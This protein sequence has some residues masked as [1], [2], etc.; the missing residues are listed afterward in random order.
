MYEREGGR[1][2]ER[3]EGGGGEEGTEG[4]REEERQG[5]W[6]VLWK[7]EEKVVGERRKKGGRKGEREEREG[8][9]CT[10]L[11]SFLLRLQ[12]SVSPESWMPR[13]TTSPVGGRSR[14][15]G[16]LQRSVMGGARPAAM[17]TSLGSL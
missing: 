7:E 15:N 16:P 4:K 13:P 5:E 9:I 8:V 6:W 3:G 2:E 11:A 14:S 10:H 12:T 17:V 1:G